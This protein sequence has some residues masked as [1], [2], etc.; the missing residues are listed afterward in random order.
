MYIPGKFRPGYGRNMLVRRGKASSP[1]KTKGSDG[2]IVPAVIPVCKLSV[3]SCA[4][5]SADASGIDSIPA[6][7]ACPNEELESTPPSLCL[8]TSPIS[9][10]MNL[11]HGNCVHQCDGMVTCSLHHKLLT[12]QWSESLCN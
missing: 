4:P 8:P 12:K 6:S 9:T 1:T 7:R 5:E 3:M 10:K 11:K 2:C